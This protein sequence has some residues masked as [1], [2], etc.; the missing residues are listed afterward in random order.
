MSVTIK[1]IANLAGVSY[2]TVSKALNGS[3]LVR[4]DTRK[5]IIR[6]AD[7]MGYLPN[8]MARSLVSKKSSVIGVAWPTVERSSWSTLVTKVN[9]ALE[10]RGYN[11]LL[12]INTV[13]AAIVTFNRL[14]VDGILVFPGNDLASAAFPASRAPVLIFGNPGLSDFPVININRRKAIYDAVCYLTER[15][16]KKISYIGDLSPKH[17]T[18]QEKFKG[19]SDG[20]ISCKLFT[21]PDMIIDSGGP[22]LDFGYK[23]ANKL[24]QSSFRPTAIVSGSYDLSLGI[25]E[26]LHEHHIDIPGDISLVSYDNIP[27]MESLNIPVTAVGASLSAATDSIVD[28]LLA[29]INGGPTFPLYSEVNPELVERQSVKALLE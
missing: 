20:V 29:L 6:I 11:M 8:I 9:E 16:H 23:A 3:P 17:V 19:F 27:Q 26:A 21:D 5:K 14:Q 4:E 2:S 1:D 22:T 28:R 12:S 10:Q 24:L 7:E 13:N 15:G 18:Q 25:I